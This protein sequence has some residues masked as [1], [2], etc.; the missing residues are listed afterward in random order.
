M[1]ASLWLC[2]LCCS[3]SLYSRP[4]PSPPLPPCRPLISDFLP[5]PIPPSPFCQPLWNRATRAT[6]VCCR[7]APLAWQ[8]HALCMIHLYES[9]R[10]LLQ[11]AN[12]TFSS[13]TAFTFTAGR[14]GFGGDAPVVE[15]GG[16]GATNR[17][18]AAVLGSPEGRARTLP[19][20]DRRVRRAGAR[21]GPRECVGEVTRWGARELGMGRAALDQGFDRRTSR[22][23]TTT[24]KSASKSRP[25]PLC[26]PPATVAGKL[27]IRVRI[28]IRNL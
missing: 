1:H 24:G 16:V 2:H 11:C 8:K 6:E 14:W 22:S 12:A 7:P 10:H 20:P 9:S 21:R 18:A 23:G 5:S 26:A 17:G 3:T 27:G 15:G 4:F 13:K 28:G 19:S 25:N